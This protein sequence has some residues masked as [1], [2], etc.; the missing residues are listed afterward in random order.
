MPDKRLTGGASRLVRRLVLGKETHERLLNVATLLVGRYAYSWDVTDLHRAINCFRASIAETPDGHPDRVRQTHGLA[1]ALLRRFEAAK[2]DADLADAIAAYE[3]AMIA[4]RARPAAT[5]VA[6]LEGVSLAPLIMGGLGTALRYRAVLAADGADLDRAIDLT[7]QAID[8]AADPSE[9]LVSLSVAQLARYDMT[10]NRADV[11]AA[12]EACGQAAE[13]TPDDDERRPVVLLSLGSLYRT[14]FRLDRDP[15]DLDAA[16]ELAR[17]GVARTRPRQPGLAARLAILRTV[18]TDRYE[19]A[20][21]RA[22]LDAAIAAG[23]QALAV[24]FPDPHRGSNLY[25]LGI[26]LLARYELAEDIA[27]A[28]AATTHLADAF[29]TPATEPAETTRARSLGTALRFVATD[30]G[31]L[32]ALDDAMLFGRRAIELASGTPADLASACLE[33]SITLQDGF[34]LRGDLS[35]LREAVDLARQAAAETPS[36][37]AARALALSNLASVQRQL[38]MY[39]GELDDVFGAVNAA[40]AS[41]AIEVGEHLGG[42]IRHGLALALYDLFFREGN[43]DVLREAVR[44]QRRAVAETAEDDRQRRGR[45]DFLQGLLWTLHERTAEP[46]LAAEAEQ[47]GRLA[48]RV[49]GSSRLGDGLIHMERFSAVLEASSGPA[50]ARQLLSDAV[51]A[52]REI[53]AGLPPGHARRAFHLSNLASV[54]RRTFEV[55]NDL[56][57]LR[58]AV[59][60]FREALAETPEGH[61]DRPARLKDL[62]LAV[63]CLGERTGEEATLAESVALHREAV[64]TRAEGTSDYAEYVVSLSRALL[65]KYRLTRDFDALQ[66]SAETGRRAVAA[67]TQLAG[68]DTAMALI[69]LSVTLE[70]MYLVTRA[71]EVLA[72]A[73]DLIRMGGSG[74]DDDHPR[75]ALVI[76]RLGSLLMT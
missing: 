28:K 66:E 62:A 42:M 31:S 51:T 26:A 35:M 33:L 23:E 56:G 60:V 1:D 11:D 9:L 16:V 65:E 43:P 52:G 44:E 58:S 32:E 22:D 74:M 59:E 63:Q 20:R 3:L 71:P 40:R 17:E 57:A 69:E 10:Q 39:S 64:A 73:I 49:P 15:A 61:A 24:T 7:R 38:A 5:G 47:A 2:Q 25:Y 29:T 37:S 41:T 6:N 12:I 54:L 36:A 53:V 30:Q 67:Y 34:D 48:L 55:T 13:L 68:G 76:G 75:R 46:E 8:H 4:L 14:R 21:D 45:L 70:Y 50:A 18:L 27:D 72:E 19:L